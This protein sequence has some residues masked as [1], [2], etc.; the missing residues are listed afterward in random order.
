MKS[1][2]NSS[3]ALNTL[4]EILYERG[5]KLSEE[6]T[7]AVSTGKGGTVYQK[8]LWMETREVYHVKHWNQ[9]WIP[10]DSTLVS[11]FAKPLDERLKFCIN[12]FG[13]GDLS[14]SGINEGTLIDLLENEMKGYETFLVTTYTS[15]EI[16]WCRT[17]DLYIFASIYGL[18]PQY[19]SSY[20][21]PFCWVPTGWF[22]TLDQLKK[23]PP[24]VV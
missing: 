20:G 5:M 3:D 24:E 18:I 8:Q 11:D 12:K 17:I 15:G 21:E 1:F 19:S 4:K 22:L 13:N 7:I 23:S 6:K 2:S 9:K 16:Y 14:A 10:K